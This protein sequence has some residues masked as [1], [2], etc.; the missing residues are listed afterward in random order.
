MFGFFLQ[1]NKTDLG[2]NHVG[3]KLLIK[4][5]SICVYLITCHVIKQVIFIVYFLMQTLKNMHILHLHAKGSV[6]KNT[7]IDI[8]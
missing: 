1:S 8:A 7:K 2:E 3:H 6:E 5:R 4:A